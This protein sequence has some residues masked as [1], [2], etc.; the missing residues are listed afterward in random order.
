MQTE[1]YETALYSGL[2]DTGYDRMTLKASTIPNTTF[3][4]KCITC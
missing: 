3:S 1:L 2:P 4:L